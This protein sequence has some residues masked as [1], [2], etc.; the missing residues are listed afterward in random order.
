MIGDIDDAIGASGW[1]PVR[2]KFLKSTANGA[3]AKPCSGR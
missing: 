1:I 2:Y 3:G